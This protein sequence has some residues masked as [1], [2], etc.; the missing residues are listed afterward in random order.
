MVA[1]EDKYKIV[2]AIALDDNCNMVTPARTVKDQTLH[3]L[4]VSASFKNPPLLKTNLL[5]FSG[6]ELWA[7]DP[8]R[9][10]DKQFKPLV[11]GPNQHP[12]AQQRRSE[13]AHVHVPVLGQGFRSCRKPIYPEYALLP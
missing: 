3:I 13:Q 1:V 11:H 2:V 10:G 4:G 6:V 8:I 7:I 5:T 12:L 9:L